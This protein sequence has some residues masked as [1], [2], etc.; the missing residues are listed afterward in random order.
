MGFYAQDQW[1]IDRLTLNLG[2]RF[3]SLY[4][5]T[6]AQDLPGAP[7]EPNPWGGF[8]R[9]NEWLG[10]RSYARREGTP[11]WK[12]INPRIGLAYDVFGN[13]RTALKWSL[14]RYVA[15]IGTEITNANNPIVRSINSVNRSW[16]DANGDYVPTCDLGNFS[17]NGECGAISNKNFGAGNPNAVRWD[18]AVL[19]GLRDSNWDMS[20]EIQQELLDGLSMTVGYYFNNAGYNQQNDSKNRVTDNTAVGTADYD[21]YCVTIPTDSR[22]PNSGEQLCGL[23]DIKPSSFGNV[24][25]YITQSQLFGDVIMRNHFFNVTLDGRLPNGIQFGGGFD[26]GTSTKNRCFVVDTPQEL[27]YCNDVTP[28]SA[29]TQ[30]KAFGSVP[31]PGDFLVSF[32]YQNLSGPEYAANLLYSSAQIEPSLGRPLSSGGY[33]SVPIVAPSTLFEDRITRLDFR[34]SKIINYNRFRFQINFDAY[35]L[36]NT[37]SI[38]TVNSTYGSRWGYPNSIIDPRI[39]EF[40]GQIDF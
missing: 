40:G 21:E 4:G 6:P 32:A 30:M 7:D 28:F 18:D 2:V 12:D 8:E 16:N 15:K 9:T 35:N 27:L 11:N 31:L 1:V 34:A 23:Y 22:L 13:G 14:G 39:L 25:S 29:Q 36:M 24:D 17:A 38:R 10:E 5:Y 37:S 20:A 26:T 33:R 3:D 19:N